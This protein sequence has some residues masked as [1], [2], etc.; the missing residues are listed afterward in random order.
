[1][2]DWREYPVSDGQTTLRKGSTGIVLSIHIGI[3]Y[4]L[5]TEEDVLAAE[6]RL[7]EWLIG[8]LDRDQPLDVIVSEADEQFNRRQ[9]AQEK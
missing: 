3:C 5:P 9:L 7:R 2:T 4:E 1:M 8:Q 6:K